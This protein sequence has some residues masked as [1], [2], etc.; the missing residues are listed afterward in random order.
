MEWD[1]GGRGSVAV[2]VMRPNLKAHDARKGQNPTTLFCIRGRD[3]GKEIDGQRL[4]VMICG[5]GGGI[6]KRAFPRLKVLRGSEP[7]MS[8][9][10]FSSLQDL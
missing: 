3:G 4:G 10:V 1:E 6:R 2:F 8:E 9:K 5:G 7:D